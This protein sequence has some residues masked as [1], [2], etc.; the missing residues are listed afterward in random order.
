MHGITG[1]LAFSSTRISHFVFISQFAWNDQ[2]VLSY[3]LIMMGGGLLLVAAVLMA[4]QRRHS[5]PFENSPLRHELISYLSRIANALERMDTPKDGQAAAEVLR[6][7]VNPKPSD[8]VRVMPK[9]H[10]K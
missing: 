8:K 5:E 1:T 4:V 9:Y 6:R 2:P 3:Q 10:T 7:L